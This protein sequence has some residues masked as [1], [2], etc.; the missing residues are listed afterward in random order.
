MSMSM[1]DF[2]LSVW[3]AAHI[4]S[5]NNSS[6]PKLIP[7]VHSFPSFRVKLHRQIRLMDARRAASLLLICEENMALSLLCSPTNAGHVSKIERR[8]GVEGGHHV[9]LPFRATTATTGRRNHAA[10]TPWCTTQPVYAFRRNRYA[11]A[12]WRR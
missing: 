8:P 7:W 2:S 10:N 5:A 1:E 9:W 12:N 3:S 11:R 6:S 4:S